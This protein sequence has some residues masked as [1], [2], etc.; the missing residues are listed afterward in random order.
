MTDGHILALLY[1]KQTGVP[2]E[3]VSNEDKYTFFWGFLTDLPLSP[4]LFPPLFV[5]FLF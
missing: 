2:V 1:R 3:I 5:L 4:P